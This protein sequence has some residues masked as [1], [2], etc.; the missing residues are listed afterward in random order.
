MARPLCNATLLR[1]VDLSS[2]EA[3]HPTRHDSVYGY[4]CRGRCGSGRR[5][6]ER[7]KSG[8]CRD[9]WGTVGLGWCAGRQTRART[10]GGPSASLRMAAHGCRVWLERAVG[11]TGVRV[12][13][14][15]RAQPGRVDR[16]EARLSGRISLAMGV[17]V[18]GCGGSTRRG[19]CECRSRRLGTVRG[20]SHAA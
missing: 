1:G 13:Q 6:R 16:D 7:G 3:W 18:H 17:V 19:V 15:V 5:A 8:R 2:G 12:E 9:F 10:R 20:A 14:R 11:N 4:T